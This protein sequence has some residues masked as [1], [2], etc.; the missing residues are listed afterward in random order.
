MNRNTQANRTPWIVFGAIVIIAII[1]RLSSPPAPIIPGPKGAMPNWSSKIAAGTM[2]TSSVNPSGAMWAGAWNAKDK[3]GKDRSAIWVIDFENQTVDHKEYTSKTDGIKWTADNKAEPA[4]VAVS[5]A[6]TLKTSDEKQYVIIDPLTNTEK[7]AFTQEELPGII[8]ETWVSPAGILILCLNQDTFSEVVFDTTTNKLNV[9]GKDGFK[10]DV[11][12]NWPDAPKKMLF[13]TYRGGF[14]VDIATAKTTKLFSYMSLTA[15]DDHWR[16]N[17]QDGRLY[18]RKDG[19]Y[20]SV[21]YKIDL[22]DIRVLDK[23]GKLSSNLLP[24]Y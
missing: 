21:S 2:A 4:A 19:G 17:V 14:K 1:V 13:V 15:N 6:P 10:T 8:Q 11:K 7:P 20:T 22:V 12:A 16:D 5:K 3:E 9:V 23:D 18:P 24:R